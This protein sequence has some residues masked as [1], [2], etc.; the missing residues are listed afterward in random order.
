M[1]T[2]RNTECSRAVDISRHFDNAERMASPNLLFAILSLAAIVLAGCS[3]AHQPTKV[4][5]SPEN[6]EPRLL[7][8]P[9]GAA[10]TY[11]TSTVAQASFGEPLVE[12][13]PI[14]PYA[15]WTEQE[16]AADALGRIGPAAVPALIEALRSPE[17][18]V[19]RKA[20]EVLGR[21][22]PDAKQATPELIRLLDD[23]DEEVRKAATRTLGRIGPPASDAVPA[24]M[25]SLLEP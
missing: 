2:K 19:R 10:A 16:A 13:V 4:I 1:L 23:S 15:Q 22:G 21:M 14:K 18:P 8:P 3:Q 17:A 11:P 6:G 7:S 12:A 25:R 20:A 24:L 9:A 5:S